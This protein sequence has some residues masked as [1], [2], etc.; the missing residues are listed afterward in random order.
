MYIADTERRINESSKIV[1]NGSFG[2]RCKTDIKKI[3]YNESIN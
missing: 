1:C 3:T 2:D